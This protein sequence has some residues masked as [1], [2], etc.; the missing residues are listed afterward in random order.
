MKSVGAKIALY[1]GPALFCML[2][3]FL[4]SNT[5]SSTLGQLKREGEFL[6]NLLTD[7]VTSQYVVHP[8]EFG[9]LAILVYR[10]LVSYPAVPVRLAVMATVVWTVVYGLLDELHQSFVA[11]RSSTLSDVGLDTGGAVIAL[12][13]VL[14][15]GRHIRF[16]IPR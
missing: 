11:G 6:P 4:L 12:A 16:L 7:F 2:G 1:W 13:L 15:L 5:T 10:L 14:L 8:T 3:I 9:I